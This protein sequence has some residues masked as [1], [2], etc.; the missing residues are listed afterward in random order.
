VIDDGAGFSPDLNAAPEPGH[1]GLTTMV[2]RAELAGGWVR[3]LSKP[4]QGA[5]V[6]CWLPTDIAAGDP[7][8]VDP[9]GAG[10]T[11]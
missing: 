1:L 8:L 2:E 7:D 5:T 9:P 6:E 4:G 11:V 10:A 3:V